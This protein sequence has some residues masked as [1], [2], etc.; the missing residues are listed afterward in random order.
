MKDSL[1]EITAPFVSLLFWFVANKNATKKEKT[2]HR[3][4]TTKQNMPQFPLWH[5][6]FSIRNSLGVLIICAR[7]AILILPKSKEDEDLYL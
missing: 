1:D 6:Q 5:L 7:R 3:Q 2:L 4:K